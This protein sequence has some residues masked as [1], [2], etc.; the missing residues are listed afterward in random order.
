VRCDNSLAASVRA[1]RDA[2]KQVLLI[3]LDNAIKHTPPQGRI[4]LET[5]LVEN[6]VLIRLRDTGPGITPEALPHIFE[7]F[8]R[9]ETS[10]TSTG[11]GLG[12]AIAKELMEAQ[13][14]TLIVES[15]LGQGSVF[16]LSLPQS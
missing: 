2:L 16:T 12:L 5:A 7:R 1:D 15:Q 10:R 11:T 8:Y 4:T 6:R 14:G 9:V 13:G 3:L